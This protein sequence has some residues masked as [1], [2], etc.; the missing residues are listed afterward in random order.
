MDRKNG[1]RWLAALLTAAVLAGALSG[2]GKGESAGDSRAEGNGGTGGNEGTGG[3]G[4][5]QAEQSKGRYVENQEPLPAELDGWDIIQMYTA[6]DKLRFLASKQE[7]GKTVLSEWEKQG[8]SYAEVTPGWFASIELPA[9]EWMEIGLAR[10]GGGEYLYTGY[11]EEDA[12]KT[13]LWKGEGDTVREITP[14]EWNVQNEETGSYEM[15]TGMAALDNGTLMTLS[16]TGVALLSGEDGSI[17]EHEQMTAFYEGGIVTDGTNAY[18][19][20]SEGSGGQIE[21]RKDGR[22]DGA[23]T[24]PYP[25][26]EG[27]EGAD[28][29][30]AVGGTGSLA[31][32]ALKD[33]TLIG[34][35]ESGI[36]R[37]AGG[38]PE[39]QWEQLASGIETDFGMS[40][41]Y[42]TDFAALEDGSIYAL[43]L[44]D[45]E[46]KLNRYE[47]DPEAVSEV[48]EVLRLY[49]VYENTLLKQAATLYHKAHPEVLIDIQYVYPMYHYEIPD[50]EAVYQELNTRL[51]GSDAPD[52]VVMDHLNMDSYSDKG[53]L[54]DLDDVVKPLEES[55]EVLANITGVYVREDGKRY[56]VPLQFGFNMAMGRDIAPENMSSIQALSEFLAQAD[57][58]YLQPQTV[59][60]LVDTFYPYFCEEIVSGKQLDREAMGRYLEYLK[61][62]GD[63]CG[64][65]A[66]RSEE[67]V[68]SGMWNL[69]AETKLA[70]QEVGG[71]DDCMFPMSMVEY[72]KGDCAAFENRFLPSMQMGIC[73]KSQYI[74]TA[75]DFL[76]FALSQQVQDTDSNGFPVNSASL[77][78]LAV[79]DRSDYSAVVSIGTDIGDGM[80]F[81]SKPYSQETA[82]K[83]CAMCKALDRP[84]KEDAKIREVLIECL[85]PYLEGSRS[86]EDTVQKIEDGLKMY[87]AE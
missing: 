26:G 82:Q 60:E 18:L 29:M 66:S 24:I 85:G 51:M 71:F 9:E 68:L 46:K 32:S 84:V 58:N 77:E 80:M 69:A 86:R 23:A 30:F 41:Y 15:V 1:R 6:E 54:A 12:F 36:F 3:N 48:K 61:T 13:H 47:Y 7:N 52:I 83:L 75:K 70:F 81:E 8:D 5:S 72:I 25:T 22:K 31:L 10:S 43:F 35:C 37:L 63:S 4:G 49:T 73:S 55:G 78:K 65:I 64:I 14:G 2:C 16:Y 21:V 74:D 11:T 59:A 38:N 53:L 19:C 39:G 50:Y 62:I 44:A 40:E 56:V 42:C 67:D 27:G 20:S 34:A 87:L 76:Q 33:G 79:K 28:A 57:Y 45:G 17:L